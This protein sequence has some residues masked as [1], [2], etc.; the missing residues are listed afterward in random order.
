MEGRKEDDVCDGVC[1][2]RSVRRRGV[3]VVV[4]DDDVCPRKIDK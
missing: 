2:P 3:V 1:C 4:V